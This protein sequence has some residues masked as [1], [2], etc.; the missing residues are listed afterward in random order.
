CECESG[1]YKIVVKVIMLALIYLDN[2]LCLE[3]E[4]A[5]I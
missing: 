3:Q 1:A 2:E 5:P 4:V